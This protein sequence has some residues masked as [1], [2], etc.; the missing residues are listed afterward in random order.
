MAARQYYSV[1]SLGESTAT[2]TY[3]A[4]CVLTFTPDANADY[5]IIASAQGSHD[6]TTGSVRVIIELEDPGNNTLWGCELKPQEYTTPKDWMSFFA[7]GKYSAGA[8]PTVDHPPHPVPV[9][10]GD[11]GADQER[12]ADRDQ[13]Q[14]R[15]QIRQQRQ[16]S[17]RRD[18]RMVDAHDVDIH[19][20][21]PGRL[22]GHRRG[23]DRLRYRRRPG[24][25]PAE[26]RDRRHHLWRS[27]LLRKERLR[28]ARLRRQPEDQ[29]QRRFQHLHLAVPLAGQLDRRDL[30]LFGDPGAA[31]RRLR[32]GVHQPGF[33][34][35]P[36]QHSADRLSGRADRLGDAGGGGAP[37]R[38]HLAPADRQQ[39]DLAVPAADRRQPV[40]DV[41]RVHAGGRQRQ[42]LLRP[43]ASGDNDARRLGGELEVAVQVRG[44]QHRLRRRPCDRRAAAGSRIDDVHRHGGADDRR[45]DRRRVRR[46]DVQRFG[47]ADAQRVRQRRCRQQR[48][49]DHRHGDTDDCR[50][51]RRGGDRDVQR[52]GGPTDR[53]VHRRRV[54]QRDLR[55]HRC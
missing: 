46:G 43:W 40:D 50:V 11:D 7:L 29:P 1:E 8:S 19:A 28:A 18:Q 27:R 33:Q 37:D 22:S 53:R 13:G 26:P 34:R 44:E 25:R 39:H 9:V 51:H 3:T 31:A 5:F 38:R 36:D 4:K 42:Q 21:Q 20:G 14:R 41:L 15:R 12:P 6:T 55:R 54:R 2:N 48:R 35:Q 24:R 52:H 16:R 49:A 30:R 17:E 45:A 47:D 32:G 23:G 10:D